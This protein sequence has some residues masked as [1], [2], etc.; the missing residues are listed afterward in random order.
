MCRSVLLRKVVQDEKEI[1]RQRG[2]AM[3]DALDHLDLV[4]STGRAPSQR[5]VYISLLRG[6]I[7]AFEVA[8]VTGLGLNSVNI[9]LCKLVKAGVVERPIRGRYRVQ[10]GLLALHLS[11]RIKELEER[12][13][14]KG[15]TVTPR[16]HSPVEWANSLHEARG[17][18]PATTA[19]EAD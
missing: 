9:V 10:E 13:V 7:A 3:N 17:S 15:T 12:M 8:G 14:K 11:D 19:M 1:D 6:C 5:E 4:L 2:L 18:K 16:P